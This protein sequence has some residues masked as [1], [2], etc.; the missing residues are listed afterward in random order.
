MPTVGGHRATHFKTT[1]AICGREFWA[2]SSRA[3]YCGPACRERNYELTHPVKNPN[4]ARRTKV[5][6]YCPNPERI[7]EGRGLGQW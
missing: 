3:K 6:S 5:D 2:N 1:C 7:I 4:M